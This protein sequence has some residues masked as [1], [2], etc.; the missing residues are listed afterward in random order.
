MGPAPQVWAAS[1]RRS[2]T[3]PLYRFSRCY[4]S[5]RAGVSRDLWLAREE[6]R[7]PRYQITSLVSWRRA[8]WLLG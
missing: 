6:Q 2:R 3:I 5:K 1:Q 7:C 8:I 4:S